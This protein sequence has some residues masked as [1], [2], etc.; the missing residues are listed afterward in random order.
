[1]IKRER[2]RFRRGREQQKR[3]K[4]GNE[5]RYWQEKVAKMG[6]RK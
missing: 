5:K 4:R 2:E 1:M 3:K 6:V